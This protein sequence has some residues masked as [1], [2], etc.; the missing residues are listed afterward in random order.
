MGISKNAKLCVTRPR[1][2]AHLPNANSAFAAGASLDF[3]VFRDSLNKLNIT[4][5]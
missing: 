5:Y 4:E 2:N 1:Q 3:G